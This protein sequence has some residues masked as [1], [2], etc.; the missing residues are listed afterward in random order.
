MAFA[1][2]KTLGDLS[3]GLAVKIAA[4]EGAA[5]QRLLLAQKGADA[6]GDRLLIFRFKASA[7]HTFRQLV[8]RKRKLVELSLFRVLFPEAIDGVISRQLSKISRQI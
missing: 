2:R 8:Q 4:D 5:I 1:D 3:D 6:R 7:G